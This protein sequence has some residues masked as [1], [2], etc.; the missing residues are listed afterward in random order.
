VLGISY[1]IKKS[2]TPVES[3]QDFQTTIITNLTPKEGDSSTIV[4]IE[5]KGLEYIE[6]VLFNG[7]E[8]V[9]LENR[10]PIKLQII[11]PA[12]T[13]LGFTIEQIRKKID[14]EGFGEPVSIK[15]LKKNGGKTDKNAVELQDI[16]FI[17]IDKGANW[18]NQCPKEEVV[19]EEVQVLEGPSISL[20][21]L[22]ESESKF[23][24]GTDLYFLHVTLPEMEE[25]LEKLLKQMEDK[26]EEQK[27][28]T[29]ELDNMKTLKSIQAMESL[30]KYKQNINILRYNIHKKLTND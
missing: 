20:E 10:T 9:I 25:K 1:D 18:K 19:E 23:K 3:F 11:P 24:E 8:C 16:N 2:R 17:Y 7:I 22:T 5:G 13:E 21:N 6:E 30:L 15:L 4:T 27:N 26:L 12:L 14:K 29:P 28:N